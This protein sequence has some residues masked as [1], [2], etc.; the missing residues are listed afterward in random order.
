MKVNEIYCGDAIK[1]VDELDLNPN[2]IILSPPDINETSF[3]LEQY[4]E[5]IKVIYQKSM[6]KLDFNGVLCSSTTDTKR[7]GEIFAKHI[8]IIESLKNYYLFYIVQS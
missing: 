8:S 4:K 1:L 3:S 2:L 6:E 7:N 5:F